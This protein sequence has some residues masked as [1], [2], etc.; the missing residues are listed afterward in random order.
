MPRGCVLTMLA[1]LLSHTTKCQIHTVYPPQP[2]RVACPMQTRVLYPRVVAA[3]WNVAG[4]SDPPSDVDLSDWLAL[5]RPA[6]IYAI[7]YGVLDPIL[8][9]P[10]ISFEP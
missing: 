9:Y 7:G 5:Q 1:S 2:H 6:D 4:C 3:P 10:G 8:R